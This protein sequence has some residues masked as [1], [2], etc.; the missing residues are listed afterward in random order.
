M[1]KILSRKVLASLLVFIT[2]T[3]F[4]WYAKISGGEWVSLAIVTVVGYIAGDGATQAVK[5]I[6]KI[7]KSGVPMLSSLTD[8]LPVSL[9]SRL[10]NLFSPPFIAA[11]VVYTVATIL[12]WNGK[13]STTEWNYVAMGTILGYNLLN[14]L[15]KV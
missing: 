1:N 2:A 6:K 11:I 3:I 8:E 7:K 13:I 12:M 14:P 10:G 5:Y 9:E 15:T 4:V